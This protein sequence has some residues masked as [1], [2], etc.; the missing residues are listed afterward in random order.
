[1][2]HPSFWRGLMKPKIHSTESPRVQGNIKKRG[3]NLLL[4]FCSM[5]DCPYYVI[6]R[7]QVLGAWKRPVDYPYKRLDPVSVSLLSCF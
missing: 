4:N 1:M 7:A 5:P 2:T 6:G 3:D